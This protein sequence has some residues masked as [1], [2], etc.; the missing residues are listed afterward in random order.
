MFVTQIFQSDLQEPNG[1][2]HEMSFLWH[3][4]E[5]GRLG[6]QR[7]LVQ[8]PHPQKVALFTKNAIEKM[9]MK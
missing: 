7:S 4:R 8:I 6:Q 1:S 9:N 3:I 5:N 2:L